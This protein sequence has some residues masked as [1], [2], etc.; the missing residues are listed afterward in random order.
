MDLT[1]PFGARMF[2]QI[3]AEAK[4]RANNPRLPGEARANSQETVDLCR[5]RLAQ[6]GLTEPEVRATAKAG[7]R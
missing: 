5:M 6:D 2:L 1:T 4:M 7:G 3:L